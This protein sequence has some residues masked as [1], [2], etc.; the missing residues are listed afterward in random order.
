[1]KIQFVYFSPTDTTKKV[2]HAM[3]DNNSLGA[4]IVEHNLTDSKFSE[5][6]T[7][8]DADTVVVFGVP[9]YSGRVPKTAVDRFQN[10]KG[11]N[12]NTIL[13]V[14]YGNRD[15]DDALLELSDIVS[16]NG[17]KV[18]SAA[19]VV[20]EHSVARQIAAGRP[21]KKDMQQLEKYGEQIINMDMSKEKTIEISGNFPYR[22]YQNTPFKPKGNKNCTECGL[23]AKMCPVNAIQADNFKITDKSVCISCM[24]CVKYC[25][26]NARNLSKLEQ[27]IAHKFILSKCNGEKENQIFF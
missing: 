4:E 21:N 12:T 18:I 10:L 27:Y 15:F 11:K 14:T 19:A 8:F 5:I 25:P 17:F 23:C 7:E 1:M 13:V 9:V 26:K 22:E 3:F 16:G 24:R 2:L 6:E 20:T